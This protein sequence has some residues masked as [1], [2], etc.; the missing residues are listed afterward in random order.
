MRKILFSLVICFSFVSQA[1]DFNI[2]EIIIH[3]RGHFLRKSIIT[4]VDPDC[5]IETNRRRDV[6]IE[7]ASVFKYEKSESYTNN[8]LFGDEQTFH[9]GEEVLYNFGRSTGKTMISDISTNG[10]VQL[11]A[12]G[13]IYV[14]VSILDKYKSVAE[15]EVTPIV[16][17][18]R[19]FKI[20][21]LVSY[22]EGANLVKSQILD[23]TS[24]GLARTSHSRSRY[25]KLSKMK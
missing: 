10:L 13:N 17:K 25:I 20:N 3:E 22:N 16:G 4:D 12:L 7:Q 6:Y 15:Y 24:N 14:E 19:V 1:C 2:G 21:D 8:P 23:I 18:S 9:L 11:F 5:R